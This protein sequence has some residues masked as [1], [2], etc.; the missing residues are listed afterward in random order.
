MTGAAVVIRESLRIRCTQAA[1]AL[2]P[3]SGALVVV[4]ILLWAY[5]PPQRLLAWLGS[6]FV[7][8]A[9]TAIDCRAMLRKID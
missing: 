9:L 7:T 8:T 2:I 5:S 6:C 4:G 1:H 3:M